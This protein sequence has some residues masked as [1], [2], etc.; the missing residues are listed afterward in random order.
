MADT[1][2]ARIKGRFTT[3]ELVRREELTEDLV[4]F[5]IKPAQPF[6]F[7]PGQYCTIGVEGIDA[8]AEKLRAA[9]EGSQQHHT[10][11]RQNHICGTRE[12][13]GAERR[14]GLHGGASFGL[15][16]IERN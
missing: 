5:W 2:S 9:V 12:S 3:C 16:R 7:K 13:P 8:S 10:C 1:V 4:K 11:E 6:I 14:R 15:T